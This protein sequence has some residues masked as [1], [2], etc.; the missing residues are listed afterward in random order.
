MLHSES[1]YFDHVS[2]MTPLLVGDSAEL[3][4][5]PTS[6]GVVDAQRHPLIRT[7][8][9]ESINTVTA[10]PGMVIKCHSINVNAGGRRAEGVCTIRPSTT[11]VVRE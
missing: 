1:E 8:S 9:E 6:Y 10:L 5:P 7:P 3:A 4:P 11:K 2:E